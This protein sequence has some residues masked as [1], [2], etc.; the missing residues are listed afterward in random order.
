MPTHEVETRR[1]FDA[2]VQK[3][4]RAFPSVDKAVSDFTDTLRLGYRLPEQPVRHPDYQDV[5]RVLVND[6]SLGSRGRGLFLVSYHK[7]LPLGPAYSPTFRYALL[8]IELAGATAA[9]AYVWEATLTTKG[10]QQTLT[11]THVS[12]SHSFS[13]EHSTIAT[14]RAADIQKFR[15][16]LR[17]LSKGL[18]GMSP[19]AVPDLEHIRAEVDGDPFYPNG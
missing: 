13:V 17:D 7:S 11:V 2:D 9:S 8:T 1:T 3:L 5:Y 10:K 6:E 15:D 14:L 19:F 12:T 4:R 16:I 18:T